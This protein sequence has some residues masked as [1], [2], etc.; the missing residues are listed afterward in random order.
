MRRRRSPGRPAHRHSAGLTKHEKRAV[1]VLRDLLG[2]AADDPSLAIS[3]HAT[4]GLRERLTGVFEAQMTDSANAGYVDARESGRKHRVAKSLSPGSTEMP[5]DYRFGGTFETIP[6]THS[7]AVAH[8]SHLITQLTIEEQNVIRNVIGRGFRIPEGKVY[9]DTARQLATRLRAELPELGHL[10]GLNLQQANALQR[11]V[12]AYSVAQLKTRTPEVAQVR[13]LRY[14][15]LL[16]RRKVHE[17]AETIAR[18]ETMKAS[19]TGFRMGVNGAVRDGLLH[20]DSRRRWSATG[21]E[22]QCPICGRLHGTVTSLHESWPEGEPPA[23]PRCRCTFVIL[24][25]TAEAVEARRQAAEQAA[26]EAAPANFRAK[27]HDKFTRLATWHGEK[28]S[29]GLDRLAAVLSKHDIDPGRL[30]HAKRR[31]PTKDQDLWGHQV[32]DTLDQLAE[33]HPDAFRVLREIHLLPDN[34]PSLATAGSDFQAQGPAVARAFARRM[35][36]RIETGE[37]RPA[38]ALT[39]RIR[40]NPSGRWRFGKGR[41]KAAKLQDDTRRSGRGFFMVGNRSGAYSPNSHIQEVMIHEFGHIRAFNAFVQWYV[42]DGRKAL[43]L[44]DTRLVDEHL[45]FKSW[46]RQAERHVGEMLE[47]AL[48]RGEIDPPPRFTKVQLRQLNEHLTKFGEQPW[49]SVADVPNWQKYAWGDVS[50][51]SATNIHEFMAETAADVGVYGHEAAK[52]SRF[53]QRKVDEA[54]HRFTAEL[55]SGSK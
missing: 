44:G 45:V 2:R 36:R 48:K 22:R 46:T 18:T 10:G 47:Q 8:T 6:A 38:D 53:V 13:T 55:K 12:D 50:K 31:V 19:N 49:K 21:D 28:T 35:R 34:S 32:A 7:Q 9:S 5:I 29:G 42:E 26:R 11:Q 27:D 17:R 20:R 40:V 30:R 3:E 33:R 14:H 41:G 43:K 52:V 24:P 25:P 51:Y 16:R 15:R 1:L 37:T 39:T 4:P 54:Q 23:H